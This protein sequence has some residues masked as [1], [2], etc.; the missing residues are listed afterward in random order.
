MTGMSRV[1]GREIAPGAHLAQSITDI[2]T[3]P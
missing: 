2:L 1:T 3:T